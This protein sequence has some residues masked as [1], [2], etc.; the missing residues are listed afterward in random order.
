MNLIERPADELTDAELEEAAAIVGV[1][2]IAEGDRVRIIAPHPEAGAIGTV[3]KIMRASDDY[4]RR[5]R[6]VFGEPYPGKQTVALTM[7]ELA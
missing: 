3:E 1:G 2:P 5:A 4:E 7:L 6:V